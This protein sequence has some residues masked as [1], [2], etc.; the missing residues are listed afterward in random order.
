LPLSLVTEVIEFLEETG[1]IEEKKGVYHYTKRRIHL[2]RNSPFIQRHHINWRSQALLSA[3]KNLP[4][5]LH[6]SVVVA[7][8]EEDFKKMKEILI[9]GIEK[10]R[11]LIGPSKEEK[12][13][14][15]TI[16]FFEM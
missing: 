2:D 3:E 9:A 15:L 12:I 4:E 1:L 7:I 10:A 13:Y 16:D 11:Q 8:S 14:A 5:D 6:Y